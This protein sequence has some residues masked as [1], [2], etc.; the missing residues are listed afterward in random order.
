MMRHGFGWRGFCAAEDVTA[1]VIVSSDWLGR[2]DLNVICKPIKSKSKQSVM[3]SS[4]QLLPVGIKTNNTQVIT[5]KNNATYGASADQ[6]LVVAERFR[7]RT[8]VG[9]ATNTAKIIEKRD[10]HRN[11]IKAVPAYNGEIFAIPR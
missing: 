1:K 8:I 11:Q 10:K 3:K 9:S 2:F 7:K 5:N 6:R 4:Q